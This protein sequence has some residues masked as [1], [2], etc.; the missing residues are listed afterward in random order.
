[1][2]NSALSRVRGS[3]SVQRSEQSTTE[4][5]NLRV[6]NAE[7]AQQAGQVQQKLTYSNNTMNNSNEGELGMKGLEGRP[8][9]TVP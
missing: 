4:I 5:S 1:M 6:A 8:S 3:A 7:H 2:T 9:A